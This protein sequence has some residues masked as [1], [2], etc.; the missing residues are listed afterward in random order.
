[1]GKLPVDAEIS[2]VKFT[3]TP[4]PFER[5]EE[6]LPTIGEFIAV[7]MK[8]LMP[9]IAT[10]KLKG[11]LLEVIKDP[12]V[13]AQLAPTLLG[14]STFLANGRL[15]WLAPRLLWSTTCICENP[16]GEKQVWELSKDSDRSYVFDEHPE[17]YMTALIFAGQV[18]FKRFFP[19]L[20]Q[21]AAAV[22][23]SR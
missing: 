3:C 4:L 9:L 16:K 18:T 10:G 6:L 5:S 7:A 23:A 21:A 13:L 2:G 11:G 20:G 19:G 22:A 17:C 15:K 8:D 14:V 12:E 1:M